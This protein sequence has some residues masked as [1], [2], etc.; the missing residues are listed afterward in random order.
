MDGEIYSTPVKVKTSGVYIIF[1][2]ADFCGASNTSVPNPYVVCSFYIDDILSNTDV[3][4]QYINIPIHKTWDN[5]AVVSFTKIL[6]E[7]QYVKMRFENKVGIA[8]EPNYNSL[9]GFNA[10]R[11]R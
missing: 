9:F 7:G 1:A 5:A 6:Y 8:S 10:F 3:F 11:L 4:R 2:I